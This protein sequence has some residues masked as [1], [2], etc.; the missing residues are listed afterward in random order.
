MPWLRTT[1][2]KPVGKRPA[3]TGK[4][5]ARPLTKKQRRNQAAAR[6]VALERRPPWQSPTVMTFSSVAVV[7]V[8][9]IVIV[10]INA[11]GGGNATVAH[12]GAAGDPDR[13]GEP[14]RLGGRHRRLR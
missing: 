1:P 11:A 12:A 2:R 13:G 5:P 14:Q 8:V 9:L 4:S 6:S 10:L 3:P 7:A